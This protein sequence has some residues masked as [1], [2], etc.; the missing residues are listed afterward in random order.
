LTA[1]A[2]VDGTVCGLG[3]SLPVAR[4]TAAITAT[5][6]ASQPRINARPFQV[7]FRAPR[8]R[9]KAVSGNGTKVIPSP[10]SSRYSTTSPDPQH[11]AVLAVPWLPAGLADGADQ[12]GAPLSAVAPFGAQPSLTHADQL[13]F[14]RLTQME[15][16]RPRNRSARPSP[17]R[18]TRIRQPER[19]D[20]GTTKGSGDQ[21]LN[22]LALAEENS[23]SVR[24]PR[25]CNSASWFS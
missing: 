10:M 25:W 15:V 7:P 12:R 13:V 23:S 16:R 21:V 8:I 6:H 3:G 18:P 4:M 5:K 24:T 2:A 19:D 1:R 14:R 17:M 22:S 20:H 9:T 11:P